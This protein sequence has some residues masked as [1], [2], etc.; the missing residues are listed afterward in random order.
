MLKGR[1]IGGGI[2][3]SVAVLWFTGGADAAESC[4]PRVGSLV[5]ADGVVELQRSDTFDWQPAFLDEG[6]CKGDSVRAGA[7]SRAAVQ[8]IN[9][10]VL[11]LDEK[12]TVRLVDIAGGEEEESFLDLV[13]G[14]FQS[15]SRKPR[16]LAVNTP[17]LNATIEGTEFVI[18]AGVDEGF[19]TVFEGTVLAANALGDVRVT[20][21]ESAV[22]KAG[23][24]PERRIV[25]RPRDAVQWSLY[26]PP[27]FTLFGGKTDRIPDDI[28]QALRESAEAAAKGDTEAAFAALDRVPAA[29]RDDRYHIFRAALLL[30]VGRVD[31]A[32]SEIDKAL[33]LSPDAGS[34]YA[35]RAVI[36]VVQ[37]DRDQ[38]LADGTKAVKLSPDS[39]AAHIALSYA[40]QAQFR[41]E[42]A[43][44][45][46]QQAVEREPENALAWARL[47]ELWLMFGYREKSQDAADK[48]VALDGGLARPFIVQGFAELAAF[49]LNKARAA[50]VRAIALSPADPL[51]RLG[52][53]LAKIRDGE[54]KNGTT[55]LEIAVALD[56]TNA[57]L[58]AY[59]G[60]AYY[61]EKRTPLDAEQFAIAKELDPL[62]PTA[63][64]YDGIRL[65][66]ENQ[67]VAA[68]EN[69]QKSIELN[70]ERVVYRSRLE[71]DSDRA[72]RQV[73]Q[74]RTYNDL[75]FSQLGLEE[76][77]SSLSLDP[78]NAS[79]HR[80]LADSYRPVRRREIA[81]VSELYQAQMLQEANLNPIQP[82]SN[83]VNLNAISQ[84][85]P[86]TVGFNEFTPLFESNGAQFFGTGMGG[87][88]DTYSTEGL[89]SGLYNNLSIA[90]GGYFYNTDG[91]RPNNDLRQNIEQIFAQYA[92]TPELNIQVELQRRAV[93]KEGDLAF[94]FDPDAYSPDL[95][96]D[97]KNETVRVG[98]RYSPTPNLDFLISYIYGDAK[99]KQ[100]D[101]TPLPQQVLGPFLIDNRV[102]D[103][104]K[105][106]DK[107]NQFEGQ[108]LY[109]EDM[110][111]IVG[112][113]AY[114]AID[115]KN[116][117]EKDQVFFNLPV[118]P[119]PVSEL[120][121]PL[122]DADTKDHITNPNGYVYAN[123]NYPERV[124]WTVGGSIDRYEERDYEN[125]SFNP[126]V[127]VQVD[128]TDSIRFRAAAFKYV[129]PPLSNNRT[130]EPTQVAGFNQFF[131]DANGT[132][133]WRW[134]GAIEWD[135]TPDLNF[136]AD[137]T[138]RKYD[139]LT[140]VGNS[141][142]LDN[143]D[144]QHHSAYA[145]WTPIEELALSASAVYDKYDRQT[146]IATNSTEA[147]PQKVETISVPLGIRW[148]GPWGLSAALSGTYVH[149]DV[150]R[151]AGSSDL[152]GNSS[153]FV[154]D[155]GIGIQFPNRLGGAG[156]QVLNLLDRDM[157]YQDD[158]YREFRDEPS[159]GPYFPDQTIMARFTLN[160]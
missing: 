134:G 43:R 30:N 79:A 60:K 129:K 151:K 102:D 41:L 11:R 114:N 50:F 153:F 64:L 70:D 85:G 139:E 121:V 81:R 10:A 7:R 135:V 98:A 127:G 31:E 4:E 126:K 53:G 82:S 20:G 34:A 93:T 131:D 6:L 107:S 94:N 57:L 150:R 56:S 132:K 16:R 52:L 148:F 9:E 103:D 100:E 122:Q 59:L 38:A 130:L 66:T 45:T 109:R 95:N 72:T 33:A 76:S 69:F 78:A 96:V 138:W 124:T 74:A 104:V 40:Y 113:F 89:V 144:E 105:V 18:G 140:F 55:D 99:E 28:P 36:N 21:G 46:M 123:I 141:Y 88:N 1:W 51:P 137:A 13:S 62:D 17:Y 111:N 128:I 86:S 136:G 61:E 2:V 80:F 77:R 84:G 115:R 106:K 75:G 120:T 83:V 125:T 147:I 22:A 116:E 142:N 32:R 159:I 54:L 12:T 47:S 92:V 160:F 65:Q 101:S 118:P 146:G 133:A 19:V 3:C 15:F 90:A 73:S 25:V 155:V 110:F 67:P 145:Y 63:F 23:A 24:A 14:V 156:I 44:E 91:F 26:Y 97:R 29:D 157:K 27:I 8:L 154:V 5:S 48:A 35:L 68:R 119:L 49:R 39:A 42:D 117:F 149:Q 87:N 112:G 37:N 108:A 158:S 143:I 58:R 71:L 152:E